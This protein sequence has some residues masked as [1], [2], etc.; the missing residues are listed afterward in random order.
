[1][2]YPKFWMSVGLLTFSLSIHAAH[3]QGAVPAP[4]ISHC[5]PPVWNAQ[6][7]QTLMQARQAYW[8]GYPLRAIRDYRYLL[9]IAPKKRLAD[10]YGEL[11]NVYYQMEDYYAAGVAFGHSAQILILENQFQGARNLLPMIRLT[12]P[13]EAQRLTIQL[14]NEETPHHDSTPVFGHRIQVSASYRRP[15]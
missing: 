4:S 3:A 10:L 2:L 6:T 7:T 12:D 13:G 9:H 11:G 1:M 14:H 5:R 8:Q 15:F